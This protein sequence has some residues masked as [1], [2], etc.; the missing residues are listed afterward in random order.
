MAPSERLL[1]RAARQ[2]LLPRNRHG[3]TPRNSSHPLP[4]PRPIHSLIPIDRSRNATI[5]GTNLVDS[6]GHLRRLTQ[7]Q[8]GLPW[9]PLL[10][11]RLLGG[12]RVRLF[13]DGIPLLL[14]PLQGILLAFVFTT[15]AFLPAACRTGSRR[16]PLVSVTLA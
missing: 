6:S 9:T 8:P 16:S 10:G 12:D 2:D 11:W 5:S 15:H 13:W 3:A 1:R 7:S 14:N 4:N